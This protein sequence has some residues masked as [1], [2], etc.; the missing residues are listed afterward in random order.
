MTFNF[1]ENMR[2]D[3][4]RDA[5]ALGFITTQKD[6]VLLRV[7]SSNSNDYI[8]IEMVSAHQ[9]LYATCSRNAINL[10]PRYLLK[11]RLVSEKFFLQIPNQATDEG[12]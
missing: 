6:A 9:T 1:P 7:T 4:K 10:A 11:M 12:S 2:P 8:E 5:I 3:T